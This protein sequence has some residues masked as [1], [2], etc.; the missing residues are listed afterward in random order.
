L[1]ITNICVKV[2]FTMD[3][4]LD[5][6]NIIDFSKK[7]S[8]IGGLVIVDKHIVDIYSGT[9]GN[10]YEKAKIVIDCKGKP[11]LPGF[12][13][14]HSKGELSCISDPSRVSAVSQGVTVE[15]LGNDGFSVAP[16]TSKN[17]LLHTQYVAP[18][19]GNQHIKWKWESLTEY[20]AF[21][22][23]R[24]STNSL[25]Y[26]PYGTLRMESTIS[27]ILSSE[28]IASL[29]Y[30][31]E[32]YI[33]EGGI[34]LS[35]SVSRS[36]SSLGWT[37]NDE[38]RPLLDILKR[39]NSILNVSLENT[40]NIIP[41]IDKAITL[42]NLF[43]LKLHISRLPFR[44]SEQCE[45]VINLFDKRAKELE[46]LI[47]DV[48]PYSTRLFRITE[49]INTE[50][51]GSMK[52]VSSNDAELKQYE[53]LTLTEMAKRRKEDMAATLLFLLKKDSEKVFM[54]KEVVEKRCFAKLFSLPYVVPA[55]TGLAIGKPVPDIFGTFAKYIED[56][57]KGDMVELSKRLSLFPAEFFG[58][59]WGVKKG[60]AANLLVLD[61]ETLKSNASFSS[62]ASLSNGV[63]LTIV[64]GKICWEK[65]GAIGEKSGQ[66]LSWI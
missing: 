54:E 28:A 62:P 59:K 42:A 30:S 2:N 12:W 8:Y 16:V 50:P 27:P 55:S 20:L 23:K 9:L 39:N 13:D 65:G 49:L 11:I 15:V 53:G 41:S 48:S 21:L 64:N 29:K 38:L 18:Y 24:V 51:A 66:V 61:T 26:L 1:S 3:I 6:A 60:L 44:T 31:V 43:N 45:S 19:L 46:Q 33:D 37:N 22:N 57:G 14:I 58:H 7:K 25:Y 35:V 32:K 17:Y 56:F 40:E 10:L 36:P 34:G 5:N 63:V 4:V 47:V 52:F